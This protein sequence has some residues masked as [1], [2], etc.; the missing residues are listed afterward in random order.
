MQLELEVLKRVFNSRIEA[1]IEKYNN[2]QH[3]KKETI[4]ILGEIS[5]III[6]L[7]DEY[8]STDQN[9]SNEIWNIKDASDDFLENL[10]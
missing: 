9:I 10:F 7:S 4:D 1:E 5:A 2:G 8:K 3:N 6:E